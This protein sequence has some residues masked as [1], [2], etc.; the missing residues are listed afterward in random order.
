MGCRIDI[1]KF[2][3]K[4]G[5]KVEGFDDKK[6]YYRSGEESLSMDLD[7]ACKVIEEKKE[8]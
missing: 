8:E 2:E 7:N 6:I 5:V 4:L 3:S 1:E